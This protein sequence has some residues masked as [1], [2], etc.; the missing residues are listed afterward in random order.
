L[1]F[2]PQFNYIP[3][4][5]KLK[6]VFDDV[7]LDFSEF[8]ERFPEFKYKLNL[9][10]RTLSGGERRFV[11]TYIVLKAKT[12][13]VILDEPFTHLMP[14]QIEK[15]RELIVEEKS[16]KGIIVTDHLYMQIL[17][18]ADD[19]YILTNSKTHF[20]K[21]KLELEESGYTL[22]IDKV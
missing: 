12:Q 7:E 10:I 14:L 8:S 3:N 5:L 15:I 17:D 18:I 19:A 11:E 21:D 9:K 6:R 20:L 2:L 16:N 13:F 4:F 22:P 1:K